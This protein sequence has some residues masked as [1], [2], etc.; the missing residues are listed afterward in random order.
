MKASSPFLSVYMTLMP[1]TTTSN[2]PGIGPGL[3]CPILTPGMRSSSVE[4]RRA[5][6][7]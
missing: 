5:L 6:S 7:A 3:I 2:S 1:F 4:R